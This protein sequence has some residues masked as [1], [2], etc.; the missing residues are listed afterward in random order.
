MSKDCL[1]FDVVT[2]FPKLLRSPLNE[3]MIR[4]A[5]KKKLVR[6]VVHDLR[7]WTHDRHRTI[8]DTPYG[9][10]AGMVLK[11]GPIIECVEDLEAKRK[12]DE[13]VYMSADGERFTQKIANELSLKRNIMVLCGHYKGI[14]ERVRTSVVTRE[15][16]VGDYVLTGGE[17]PALVVIDAV[18]RLIPGVLGDGESML[19]DS[20]QDGLLDGPNYTRPPVFRGERVPDVLLSGDHKAIAR[21][22]QERRLE[23]TKRRRKDLLS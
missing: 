19:T 10:G 1:R 21:W 3:S 22:R 16:S 20:F 23:R 2:G 6:I 14:D 18:I 15:L 13:I 9:G 8:D 4:Q 5:K 11:P 7:T 17:L 12:Y